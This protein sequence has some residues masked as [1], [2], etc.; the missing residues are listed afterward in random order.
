MR[1]RVRAFSAAQIPA[2]PWAWYYSHA[3]VHEGAP[4][5]GVSCDA[6]RGPLPG[7]SR[8]EPPGGD[9]SWLVL[10]RAP[11]IPQRQRGRTAPLLM[12]E[13]WRSAP[14]LPSPPKTSGQGPARKKVLPG[15]SKCKGGQT[16]RAI[17][18]AGLQ[19]G[20]EG[21][22]PPPTQARRRLF[23]TRRTGPHAAPGVSAPPP[24]ARTPSSAP[25]ACRPC[26]R[27]PARRAWDASRPPSARPSRS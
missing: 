14:P 20:G 19:R 13:P 9:T 4:L 11:G 21:S 17:P 16:P 24:A 26:A 27:P 7:S 23:P 1:E 10:A 12:P 2:P 5:E 15:S 18:T 6:S 25:P 22:D 8:K 3:S